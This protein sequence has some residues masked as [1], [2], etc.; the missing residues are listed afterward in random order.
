MKNKNKNKNKMKLKHTHIL[1][2]TRLSHTL[3]FSSLHNLIGHDSQ[4]HTQTHRKNKAAVDNTPPIHRRK[5][6][7]SAACRLR[8]NMQSLLT[9]FATPPPP[10]TPSSSNLHSN[11]TTQT[12]FSFEV[13]MVHT[14]NILY[15]IRWLLVV[16]C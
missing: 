6:R 7:C 5:C 8:H 2:L 3:T 1:W 4:F 13:S 15:I 11:P 12:F 9:K 14:N 16:N 10:P